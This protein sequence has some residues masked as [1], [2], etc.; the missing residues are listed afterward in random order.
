MKIYIS[1]FIFCLSIS[2]VQ[3]QSF[4]N[5]GPCPPDVW[6]MDDTTPNTNRSLWGGMVG[7][8]DASG[9]DMNDHA[10]SADCHGSWNPSCIFADLFPCGY[11]SGTPQSTLC[12][13]EEVPSEPGDTN[14]PSQNPDG[15]SP[16]DDDG[17]DEAETQ[18]FQLENKGFTAEN[19]YRH[20]TK[21]KNGATV[22][23]YDNDYSLV[24]DKK[25]R[26]EKNGKYDMVL[27]FKILNT[28][29]NVLA[30]PVAKVLM[31]SREQYTLILSD[32]S[33]VKKRYKK[34]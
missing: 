14:P 25:Y 20:F 3:A 27:R 12:D 13:D 33:V 10:A 34:K 17:G 30:Q 29:K 6:C 23:K 18:V 1:L 28:K 4:L 5:D 31:T 26:N 2:V 21:V 16:G 22:F 8:A 15:D 7:A 19:I 24:L 32:L 9:A 11:G